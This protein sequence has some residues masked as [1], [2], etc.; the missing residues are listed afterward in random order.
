MSLNNTT[1]RPIQIFDRNDIFSS[2]HTNW[3]SKNDNGKK[4]SVQSLNMFSYLSAVDEDQELSNFEME[5]LK[6]RNND[7]NQPTPAF[8]LFSTSSKLS[9]KHLAMKCLDVWTSK[10]EQSGFFRHTRPEFFFLV[11]P[12]TTD[13]FMKPLSKKN[14]N[15]KT[16]RAANVV[17]RILFDC[18]KV[19]CFPMKA[20][21]PWSDKNDVENIDLIKFRPKQEVDFKAGDD[22]FEKYEFEYF[23]HLLEMPKGRKLIALMEEYFPNR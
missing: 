10:P 17:F 3:F 19:G 16:Y 14:K 13:Y 1:S 8:T 21:V 23:L 15:L 7:W 4:I 22:C 18:E 5:L 12:K 2:L 11:W 9:I 20:M 6:F